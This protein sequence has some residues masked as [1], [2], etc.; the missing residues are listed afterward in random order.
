M[1]LL[2]VSG[3]Q[4]RFGGLVALDRVSFAVE[5]SCIQG[6]I[7][8]NGAGKT[9]LFNIISGVLPPTAGTVTLDGRRLSGLRPYQVAARGVARTFQS[10]SLFG[11]MTARENVLLGLH[12]RSRATLAGALLRLPGQRREEARLRA[13]ADEL[14]AFVGMGGQ[15]DARADALPFGRRRMVE[16]ARALA[17]QPRLLLLD[18]PASGLNTRE[19]QELADLIRRIR[20]RGT[21]VL[22][23]EHDMSLV[24]DVCDRVLVL[25]FGV[26][27]AEG[28]P[29]DVQGDPRV[30]AVYLGES[31]PSDGEE[32]SRHA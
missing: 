6:I 12:V 22:L 29:A 16:L 30:M 9:T 31:T 32:G 19:T 26:P 11:R 21:T 7:G 2:E 20:D 23:V 28:A 27:I 5:P 18:E 14:L 1:A 17:A 4:R 24:M 10:V 25:H 3:V 15:A 13:Q 8:P